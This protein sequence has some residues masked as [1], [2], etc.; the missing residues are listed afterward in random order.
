MKKHLSFVDDWNSPASESHGDGDTYPESP[1]DS[2]MNEG[3]DFGYTSTGEQANSDNTAQKAVE[4]RLPNPK[5]RSTT[6]RKVKSLFK[7]IGIPRNHVSKKV[8]R[9]L[10]SRPKFLEPF[11]KAYVD[12]KSDLLKA[13]NAQVDE[14]AN[15]DGPV[16]KE[17]QKSRKKGL[18]QKHRVNR[19][20]P[21]LEG[22][23][24]AS[25]MEIADA[26]F[27]ET[28]FDHLRDA[29]ELVRTAVS[30]PSVKNVPKAEEPLDDGVEADDWGSEE[31]PTADSSNEQ[32]LA[33]DSSSA[34][35]DYGRGIL[36]GETKSV[37]SLYLL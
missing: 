23:I 13:K 2:G 27:E 18:Q 8:A 37:P 9:L 1:S 7:R 34:D 15:T 32:Q 29:L 24:S 30:K 26:L 12:A 16:L 33:V 17:P 31:P 14:L 20:F 11:M 5:E 4:K 6:S 10:K 36:D 28:G 25:D 21:E 35:S 3:G 22:A 19:S